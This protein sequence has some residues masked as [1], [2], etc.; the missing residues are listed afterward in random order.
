MLNTKDKPYTQLYPKANLNAE[1]TLEDTSILSEAHKPQDHINRTLPQGS[2]FLLITTP[3]K[4]NTKKLIQQTRTSPILTKNTKKFIPIYIFC[5]L[6]F[7]IEYIYIHLGQALQWAHITQL[8]Y[9][10]PFRIFLSNMLSYILVK[11]CNEPISL[12][13]KL[14]HAKHQVLPLSCLVL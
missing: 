8:K 11:H 5:L 1:D 2:P 9:K 13:Y 4:A 7:A 14:V 10:L 6:N 12:K 3:L